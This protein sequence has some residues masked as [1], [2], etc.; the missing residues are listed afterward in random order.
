MATEEAAAPV[1]PT[2]AANAASTTST[3]GTAPDKGGAATGS[4]STQTDTGTLTMTQ[5]ELDKLIGERA[6]RAKDAGL[7]ELLEKLGVE[8]PD[9]LTALVNAEKQRAEAEMS[10][11]EKA[12][13]AL[14]RQVTETA[15]MKAQLEAFQAKANQDRLRYAITNAAHTAQAHKAEAVITMLESQHSD[16]LKAALGEGGEV[17]A[18]KVEVLVGKLK[19]SDPYLFGSGTERRTPGSQS[20]N[21]GSAPQPDK[22]AKEVAARQLSQRIRSNF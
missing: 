6:K 8:D 10:E 22:K 19:E 13:K 20:N 5:A 4:Q 14:E 12:N 1:T 21:G 16:D 9:K 2:P 17:D 11:V 18:K 3:T 15:Q 7:K